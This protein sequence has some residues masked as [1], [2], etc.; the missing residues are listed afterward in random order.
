MANQDF[1]DKKFQKTVSALA[2]ASTNR[3][4]VRSLP[5][6][7]ARPTIP[8]VVGVGAVGE[9]GGVASPFTEPD[10]NDR[11]YHAIPRTV[12]STDGVFTIEI[13]DIQTVDMEDANGNAVNFEFDQPS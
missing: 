2:K 12:A 11:T 13:R 7:R 1:S 5:T 8:G 4:V 6:T 9:A 3:S 10:A